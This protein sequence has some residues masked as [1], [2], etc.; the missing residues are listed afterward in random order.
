M[1]PEGDITSDFDTNY[2]PISFCNHLLFFIYLVL[3]E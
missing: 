1:T 3:D 2:L